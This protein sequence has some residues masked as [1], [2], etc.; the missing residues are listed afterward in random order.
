MMK[1]SISVMEA[2]S[3]LKNDYYEIYFPSKYEKDIKIILEYSTK[4]LIENLAFFNSNS[5]G[6]KIKVSFFDNKKDFF[7]RIKFLDENANPPE[8]ASGCFYGGENQ[9]LLDKDDLNSKFFTLAHESCHLLFCK[10]IYKYYCERIVWLDESFAANFSGEVDKELNNGI[11]ID[12]IKK[13]IN[14]KTLP[15]MCDISFNKNNIVTDEYN[16]Y[17][18]FHIVGR[19]LLEKYT[20]EKLLDLYKDLNEIKKLGKTILTDSLLYF[21]NKYNL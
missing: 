15:K 9:I 7:A 2:Y 10:Y 19:Y 6:Q 17:D 12:Y 8:W 21:K 16:A 20:K 13:Y 5:Y 4:K 3:Q 11:F 18:L 14:N 1:G